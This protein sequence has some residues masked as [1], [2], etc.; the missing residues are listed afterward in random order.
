MNIVKVMEDIETLEKGVIIK[1][2]AI[3]KVSHTLLSFHPKDVTGLPEGTLPSYEA[4]SVE[5]W[6]DKLMV[7]DFNSVI[8]QVYEMLTAE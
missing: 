5:L 3:G 6:K 8:N 7:I 1:K 4:S 2:G